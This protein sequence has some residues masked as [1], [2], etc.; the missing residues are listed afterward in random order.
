MADRLASLSVLTY[1][2]EQGSD[3]AR[4]LTMAVLREHFYKDRLSLLVQHE[5]QRFNA[6]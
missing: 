2:A 1:S 4:R 6:V 5:E 3:G